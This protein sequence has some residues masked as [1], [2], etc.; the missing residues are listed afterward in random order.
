[1]SQQLCRV[2]TKTRLSA[3]FAF[4]RNRA[5]YDM[6]QEYGFE[7]TI[8]AVVRVRAESESVAREVLTSSA[9][10]SPSTDE[11]RLANQA[12]FVRGTAATV[13]SVDFSLEEDSVKLI[14]VDERQQ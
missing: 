10:A 8:V 5:N 4:R 1:M 12:E 6:S 2:V 7:I 14:E 3:L 9:L 11:I 13:V